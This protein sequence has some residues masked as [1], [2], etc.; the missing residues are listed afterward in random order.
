MPSAGVSWRELAGVPAMGAAS[1]RHLTGTTSGGSGPA[2]ES[3]SPHPQPPLTGTTNGEGA[4]QAN[5]PPRQAIDVDGTSGV[6]ET[7][8]GGNLDGGYGV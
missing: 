2:G 1:L 6:Q 5:R 4:R 7:C 3:P 8:G